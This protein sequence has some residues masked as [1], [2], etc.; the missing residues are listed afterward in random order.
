MRLEVR[1]WD[2]SSRAGHQASGPQALK[3]QLS[4][5]Q[6][7]V[8]R[9]WGLRYWGAHSREFGAFSWEAGLWPQRGLVHGVVGQ[10]CSP[11]MAARSMTSC[12]R[13]EV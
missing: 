3:A 10:E 8:L 1:A 5:V 7:Q 2:R 11:L 4:G 9:V 12:N 6:V 13:D